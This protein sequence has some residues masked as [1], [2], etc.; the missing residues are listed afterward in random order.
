MGVSTSSSSLFLVA[1]AAV[2]SLGYGLPLAFAPLTWARHFGWEVRRDGGPG[3]DHDPLTVYL[4]RC[5]GCVILSVAAV[6]VRAAWRPETQSVLLELLA[7]AFGSMTVVHLV[8]WLQR[9]QPRRETLELPGYVVLTALALW[10]R[11]S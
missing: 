4:G 6:A 8:G 1:C 9:T 2:F 7:L 10:L 11:Y 3:G 5:L